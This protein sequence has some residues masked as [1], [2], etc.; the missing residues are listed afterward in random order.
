MEDVNFFLRRVL[1]RNK[2]YTKI[3]KGERKIIWVHI[4][5]LRKVIFF[6]FFSYNEFSVRAMLHKKLSR[7]VGGRK[8]R[9]TFFDYCY[10]PV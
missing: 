6:F 3:G 1:Q 4:F 2:K 10:L 5:F 8:K 7:F 9:E